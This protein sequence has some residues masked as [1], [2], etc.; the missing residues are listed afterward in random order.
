MPVLMPDLKAGQPYTYLVNAALLAL[1]GAQPTL[2][3]QNN[4][5]RAL[6]V[7]GTQTGAYTLRMRVNGR[8]FD[9]AAVNNANLVGTAAAPMPLPVPVEWPK[10]AV[11]EFELTDTS[12]APNAVQLAFIGVEF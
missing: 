5:F 7:T 1:G 8:Q 3:I 11:V 12:G 6:F 9:N 2:Q 4:N 10:G